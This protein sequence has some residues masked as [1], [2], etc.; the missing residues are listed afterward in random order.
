MRVIF[1]VCGRTMQD[2]KQRNCSI[3]QDYHL[4]TSK[5]ISSLAIEF[6]SHQKIKVGT[7]NAIFD[8]SW[9]NRCLQD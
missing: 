7:G 5:D 4:L 2:V 1:C 8:K 3:Y 6:E 9:P